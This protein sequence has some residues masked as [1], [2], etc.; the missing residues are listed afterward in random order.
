MFVTESF[1]SSCFSLQVK[2][3]K[4]MMYSDFFDP[5]EGSEDP[6]AGDRW[7]KLI[8]VLIVANFLFIRGCDVVSRVYGCVG[9]PQLLCGSRSCL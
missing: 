6:P 3:G 5:V 1:L 9:A 7:D 2:S 4:Q 8:A